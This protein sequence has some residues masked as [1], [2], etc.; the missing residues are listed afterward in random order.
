M[1]TANIKLPPGLASRLA[2]LARATSEASVPVRRREPPARRPDLVQSVYMVPGA[3]LPAQGLPEPLDLDADPDPDE[4]SPG[5]KRRCYSL[6]RRPNSLII[7]QNRCSRRPAS[8]ELC[9]SPSVPHCPTTHHSTRQSPES[10]AL[11]GLPHRLSAQATYPRQTGKVA[12]PLVRA[13]PPGMRRCNWTLPQDAA[14][15]RGPKTFQ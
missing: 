1:P 11:V 4:P 9:K 3:H 2:V 14:P 8:R 15:H 10:D 12:K 7:P 13:V 5:A 6:D